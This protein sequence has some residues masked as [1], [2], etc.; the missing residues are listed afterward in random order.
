MK[1]FDEYKW[2]NNE[3]IISIYGFHFYKPFSSFYCDSR[4][5][6][7]ITNLNFLK[8]YVI[9]NNNPMK[10]VRHNSDDDWYTSNFFFS[11]LK[12]DICR[13]LRLC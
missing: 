7:I 10:K 3:N 11:R 9:K 13:F 6:T 5:P 12:F 1:H 2:Y 4:H 8:L